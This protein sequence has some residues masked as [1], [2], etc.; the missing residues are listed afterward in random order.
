MNLA[1]LSTALR[2]HWVYFALAMVLLV[3]V[4]AL[5]GV[6][7]VRWR[8]SPDF[9]WR[10]MYNS[11]PNVVAEGFPVGEAAGLWVGDTIV[12]IN[13]QAYST[14]SDL[15]LKIRHAQPGSTNTYTVMRDGN[16]T[17]IVITTGRLGLS[18]VLWRSGILFAIGLIYAII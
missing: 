10:T 17:E 2:L 3:A 11:G 16:P 9:G 4:Y 7:V 18:T 13:G 12:A 5:N 8:Y 15:F 14:F 6:N 1:K